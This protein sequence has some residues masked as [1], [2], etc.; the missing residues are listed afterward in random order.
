MFN[1]INY[2]FD[3]SVYPISVKLKMVFFCCFQFT[4]SRSMDQVFPGTTSIN[5]CGLT[6]WNTILRF[7]I[8]HNPS[9][10]DQGTDIGSLKV[11]C[12]V[13]FLFFSKP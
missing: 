3:S 11:V 6:F 13:P 9:T 8:I 1:I 5:D 7:G 4:I 10:N 2:S 12:L